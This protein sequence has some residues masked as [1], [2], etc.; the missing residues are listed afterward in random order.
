MRLH[1]SDA[2]SQAT[3]KPHLQIQGW[4]FA[5]TQGSLREGAGAEGD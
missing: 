2:A 3:D 1:P 4:K 5:Q